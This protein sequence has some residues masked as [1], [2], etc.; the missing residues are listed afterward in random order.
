M[1]AAPVLDFY[2]GDDLVDLLKAS[3]DARE[4]WVLAWKQAR[5]RAPLPNGGCT[6]LQ[7]AFRVLCLRADELRAMRDYPERYDAV[8]RFSVRYEERVVK[9]A[10]DKAERTYEDS[11]LL[12]EQAKSE[13]PGFNEEPEREKAIHWEGQR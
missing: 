9:Y 12:L 3:V 13:R 10:C 5:T 11:L 7:R 6:S 4:R 8:V 2:T 1:S